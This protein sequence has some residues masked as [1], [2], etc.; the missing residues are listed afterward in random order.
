M[1]NEHKQAWILMNYDVSLVTIV[2]LV[3][4][5]FFSGFGYSE[6]LR[7][8]I[9]ITFTATFR[10]KTIQKPNVHVTISGFLSEYCFL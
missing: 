9:I 5:K 10:F 3:I 4:A 1:S 6:F 8:V 7:P 2:T